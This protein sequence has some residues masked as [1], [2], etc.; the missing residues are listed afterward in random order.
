MGRLIVTNSDH[1]WVHDTAAKFMPKLAIEL[2][3]IPVISARSIF[4]PQGIS[5]AKQWKILCFR[6]IVE[7]FHSGPAGIW[8][9]QNLVS[10]GDSL[11]E[12]EATMKV[13]QCCPCYVKSLKLLERPNMIQLAQ[14]LELCSRYLWGVS[15]HAGNFD[16]DLGQIIEAKK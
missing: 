6:R 15:Y 16:V 10:I 11:D 2:R 3:D 4:E 7:C 1:G 5:D 8:G 14:Q 13:A 9:V 12:Q